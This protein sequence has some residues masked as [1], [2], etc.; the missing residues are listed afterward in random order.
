MRKVVVAFSGGLDTS[1][2]VIYLK[3]QG[4]EVTTMTVDTGGFSSGELDSIAERSKK[5][6]AVKHKTLDVCEEM[7]DRFAAYVV[8]GNI[9]RGDVYPLCVGAERTIQAEKVVQFANEIGADAVCHGSTGAGNDQVRF[10]LACKCIDAKIEL[11]TPI[12]ELEL[13]REDELS[14]L[15]KHGIDFPVENKTYSIN[16][17]I[18][19][20]TIG[21][22]ETHDSWLSLPEQAYTTTSSLADAP[23]E[24]EEVV[25]SFVDGLP[26]SISKSSVHAGGNCSGYQILMALNELGGKHGFGRS[27]HTGDT[28]LGIKGRIAFEAPGALALVSAHRELEKIILT[29]WQAYVKKNVSELYGMLLHEGQWFDPAMRDI[30]QLID[31]SQKCVSGEVKISFHKGNCVVSGVRSDNSLMNQDVQYGEGSTLWNGRDAEGFCK[32][33]GV[34]ASLAAQRK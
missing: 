34:Q 5:L 20:T 29:K 7:F 1:F 32:I 17:G 10:D 31:S 6:G 27:V 30:E 22:G 8:K 21:G 28:I 19:G 24:A 33:F 25:L 11:I 4:F 18:L 3:E 16:Q 26:V 23:A 15:S 12:R 13:S 9:L 14:F 2:C